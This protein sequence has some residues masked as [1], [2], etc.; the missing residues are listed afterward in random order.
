[1]LQGVEA[2]L[3]VLSPQIEG[4]TQRGRQLSEA[5]KV[6]L[7]RVIN[8]ILP[9]IG[10]KKTRILA[11]LMLLIFDISSSTISKQIKFL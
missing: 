10:Q 2:Q 5:Q 4:R 1:M 6:L 9:P 3:F 11:N 7:L 8:T